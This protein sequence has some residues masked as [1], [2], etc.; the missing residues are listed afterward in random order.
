M[1]AHEMQTDITKR[2]EGFAAKDANL[3]TF[4]LISH[5]TDNLWMGG[6]IQDTRLPKEFDYVVSM[7]PWEQY[8]LH[9]STVRFEYQ[10]YDH[11]EMP[12]VPTLYAAA[13]TVLGCLRSGGTT[14]VHCQ[15][16]LNRSG[17]VTGLALVLSGT[18]PETAI[19]ML[20][21]KR[22]PSVLCNPVFADWLRDQ[23]NLPVLI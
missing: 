5:I 21:H 15:A 20:R 2:I 6:C 19:T 1:D 11:A 13:G 17:L 12:D 7:Y 9:E 10:M 16:G 8:A 14:L 18:D 22:S 4:E 23:E 3:S